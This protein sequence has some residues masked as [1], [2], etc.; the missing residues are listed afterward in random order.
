M[1]KFNFDQ[2]T[3]SVFPSREQMGAKAAQEAAGYVAEL[4]LF[5][6]TIRCVFA[7]APSQSDFLER[8]FGD[9][10][11]DFSRIE[12]FHM[13]EYTGLPAEDP[14]SFRSYLKQFFDRVTFKTVHFIDGMA[15]PE[16]ECARYAALLAQAPIDIVFM[17]IGENGH[18][19]F[20]D[21][22]VADFNDSRAVKPVLLDL[23]CRG[24]QVNDGC[25]ASLDEVPKV[26]FTLTVPTLL[27]A[28]KHFCIVPTIN[29]AAAVRDTLL[30]SIGEHCPATALRR[31]EGVLMYIDEAAFSLAA[32]EIEKQA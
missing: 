19:A 20:N 13:D 5:K 26:A 30:G 1:K 17:G 7:A 25:F 15:E 8:F 21:P 28:Q 3:L 2:I 14:R 11:V 31:K 12:A 9:E 24:Q 23:V 4:L 10:R 16:A 32:Q 29:K 6:E 18:I 27:C 22:D